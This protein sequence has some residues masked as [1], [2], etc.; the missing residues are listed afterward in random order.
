MEIASKLRATTPGLTCVFL[1]SRSSI[2]LL[3]LDLAVAVGGGMAIRRTVGGAV[4]GGT[5]GLLCGSLERIRSLAHVVVVDDLVALLHARDVVVDAD[6][7]ESRRVLEG[8]KDAIPQ[9]EVLAVVVVEEEVVVR[10]VGRAVDNGLEAVRH[11]VVAVVDRG[12]PQVD[13][14]KE[15][16]VEALVQRE[17]KRVEVVGRAL[18]KAINRVEGMRGKGR[19]DLPQVVRLVQ[20]RVDERVVQPAVHPVD[21]EI[22]EEDEGAERG[23]QHGVAAVLLNVL[24]ELGVAVDLKEEDDGGGQGHAG[25]RGQGALDLARHLV[26]HAIL[27]AEDLRVLQQLVVEDKVVT[28][29]GGDEV[30]ECAADVDEEGQG[31]QLTPHVVRRPGLRVDIWRHQVLIHKVKSEIHL[32][33]AAEERLLWLETWGLW[34][35]VRGN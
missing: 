33:L 16:E 20:R 24:V 18:G 26:R 14:H 27:V 4:G 31:Q 17:D 9:R 35:T 10:V 2:L 6:V 30:D 28:Q 7:V 34:K 19:R 1:T 32:G 22:R 8:A 21:A 29:R 11:A 3:G 25:D 23:H 13:N 15:H 5:I 12:A